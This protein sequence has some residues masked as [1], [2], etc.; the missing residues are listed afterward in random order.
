MQRADP[1]RHW[2]GGSG[3]I[4][5]A[6]AGGGCAQA[7]SLHAIAAR[8]ARAEREDW[9]MTSSARFSEVM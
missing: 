2:A 4:G 1:A 3:G 6:R 5:N 7:R 8:S 9:I